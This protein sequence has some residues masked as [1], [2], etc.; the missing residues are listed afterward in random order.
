MDKQ[1]SI[2]RQRVVVVIYL[3]LHGWGPTQLFLD[4]S[5]VRV[6]TSHA[7]GARDVM[8][9]QALVVKAQYNLRHLIHANHLITSNVN[10][11]R[12][13]RLCK[14]AYIVGIK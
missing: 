13:F 11:L 2:H 3:E 14:P 9:R 10:R 7:L 6:A 1:N 8:D 12:K 4:Q 5:V